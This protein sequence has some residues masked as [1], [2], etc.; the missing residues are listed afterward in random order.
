MG[1]IVA[2]MITPAILAFALH[3][4]VRIVCGPTLHL[5]IITIYGHICYNWT[6]V[7]CGP[8][9]PTEPTPA[10][11]TLPRWMCSKGG[12]GGPACIVTLMYGG[13]CI[14]TLMYVSQVWVVLRE[15]VA[16]ESIYKGSTCDT[17]IRVT[18]HRP[19]ILTHL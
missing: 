5:V 2:A 14:V 10:T 11:L 15:H 4:G 16:D 1:L 6:F 12:L 9:N 17:Y 8:T 18:V 7:V 3:G 19:R 13:L